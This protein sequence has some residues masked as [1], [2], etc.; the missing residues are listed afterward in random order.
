[1]TELKAVGITDLGWIAAVGVVLVLTAACARGPERREAEPAFPALAEGVAAEQL[2]RR[3]TDFVPVEI[4]FDENLLDAV[5]RKVLRLLVEA[6]MDIDQLFLRQVS[7][8]NPEWRRALA[9]WEAPEAASALRFFDL[10]FGPWDRLDHDRPLLAV[11]PK[12][13]GA[14]Y[15]PADLTQEEFTAWIEQHPDQREAFEGYFTV[16][17]RHEAGGLVAVP[18]AEAYR[19]WLEPAAAKL[20]EAAALTPDPRLQRYLATR[21]DAFESNNYYESDLAWMDLGDGKIEVVIGPYEV[22]ED[23]LMGYKAAF[24]SFVTV[25]DPEAS[26][27]L[28][29][30]AAHLPGLEAALPYDD[31]YK[32]GQRGAESPISVVDVAFTGGDTKAGVQTTAFNLPNDER[33]RQTKGSK[34][35]M[36]RNVARAKFG[37]SLIP[38]ARIG[39]VEEQLPLITFDA[40]FTHVLMHEMA[41]GVGPGFITLADGTQTDVNRA[42]RELYA[43]VEE[44]KADIVGLWSIP[45]LVD[46]GEF[47][48]EFEQQVYAS[49]LGG[50]FRSVRFGAAAAHGKA[51]MVIYNWLME[52]EAYVHDPATGRHRVEMDRMR[53]AVGSLAHE[54]L[55]LQAEGDYDRAKLLLDRYGVMPP[56]LKAALD[57]MREVPVDIAPRYTVLEEMAAW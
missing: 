33:V 23:G 50:I 41:H 15:Y 22:Y 16:I 44:A 24:E 55:T 42:L 10:M 52:R 31:R 48:D 11:G 8:R 46:K 54:I 51:N 5:E 34:K 7:P 45:H 36:L 32:G 13:A 29:R 3:I 30:L 12:P 19:E 26:A 56:S 21:A 14:G 37:N 39:V 40:Y 35:V 18:Y 57:R 43:P 20:R 38:L 49:F 53:E 1:M 6:A 2:D 28:A 25:R 4:G 47:P 17:R 27:Q 9:T